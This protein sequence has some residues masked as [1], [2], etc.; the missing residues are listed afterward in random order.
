[1]IFVR[2]P[3]PSDISAEFDDA[4]TGFKRL[5]EFNTDIMKSKNIDEADINHAHSAAQ[6]QPQYKRSAHWPRLHRN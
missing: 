3:K 6:V 4:D 5:L 2:R 1:V